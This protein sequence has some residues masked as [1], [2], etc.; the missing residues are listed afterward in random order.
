MKIEY[1]IQKIKDWVI[2]RNLHLADPKAQ[3]YKT[4]IAVYPY[5]G[6]EKTPETPEL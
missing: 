2:E 4:V 1:T 6:E 3:M 5:F